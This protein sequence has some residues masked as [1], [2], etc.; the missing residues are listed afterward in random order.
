MEKKISY[1]S[2]SWNHFIIS[3]GV[4]NINIRLGHVV[5]KGLIKGLQ[6]LYIH[7]V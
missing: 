6:N 5:V 3:C 2:R 1:T 7:H 4:S